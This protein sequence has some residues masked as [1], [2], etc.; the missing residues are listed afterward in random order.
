V[1][2]CGLALSSAGAEPFD[3]QLS[4]ASQDSASGKPK[5]YSN[6]NPHLKQ[7]ERFVIRMKLP[8]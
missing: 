1:F 5:P 6:R 8:S 7:N 3:A 2:V 4:G